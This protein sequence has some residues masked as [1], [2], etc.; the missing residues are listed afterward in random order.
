MKLINKGETTFTFSLNL[1]SAL[2]KVLSIYEHSFWGCIL[3]VLGYSNKSV[4]ATL[5]DIQI[6]VIYNLKTI[7]SLRSLLLLKADQFKISEPSS[8]QNQ[9]VTAKCV[10]D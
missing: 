3:Y 1:F 5:H 8:G 6:S 9:I 4:V 2:E 10:S 7:F